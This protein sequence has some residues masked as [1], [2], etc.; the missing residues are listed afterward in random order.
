MTFTWEKYLQEK[1]IDEE[2]LSIR[3]KE[4]GRQISQDYR[5]R[6]LLLICILKGGVMF[7]TDLMRQITIPH[8]IDFLA[9]SSYGKGV[10]RSTGVVR[11]VKDLDQPIAGRDVLIVEDIV[12]SGHTLQY[13][14]RNLATRGPASLKICTLLD[15]A[16]RREVDIE[17]D[18][19]GFN[20][21][22]KFVFGF[23]LDVDQKFRELPFIG[24]VKPDVVI[25]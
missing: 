24:V 7:L 25:D 17:V 9:V 2:T 6:D 15:K 4:L 13:I 5:H 20:I 16:D 22:D 19:V 3:I 8:E 1:L 10:R 18:Y 14:T 11:I 23:G 21:P 12:D